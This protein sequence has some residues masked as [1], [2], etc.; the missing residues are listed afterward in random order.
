MLRS[1]GNRV[2]VLLTHCGFNTTEEENAA[3]EMSEI[4]TQKCGMKK[5]DIVRVSSVKKSLMGGR[6]VGQFGK[7]EAIALIIRNLW[8]SIAEKIPPVLKSFGNE[9]IDQWKD[10]CAEI[11]DNEIDF[12]ITCPIPLTRESTKKSTNSSKN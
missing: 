4:L 1:E 12:L 3:R 8:D 11:I 9:R 2:I 10:D 5:H 7:E 6:A